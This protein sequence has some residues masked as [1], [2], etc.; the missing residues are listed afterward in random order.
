MR[1]KFVSTA[2]VAGLSLVL[3]TGGTAGAAKL[4]TGKDI[5][6]NSITS[7]DVRDRSLTPADFNGSV[8]GPAGPAGPQGA[9][10]TP[11][12]PGPKGDTGAIGP[13]GPAGPAG[14]VGPTGISGYELRIQ[15][16]DIPGRDY[17]SW[18]VRCTGA[19]KAFGGGV[20]GNF[21]TEVR[22]SAP[23]NE[24]KGWGAT[25]FNASPADY[26]AYVW[27]ICANAS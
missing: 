5:K 17:R 23:M 10:G 16:Q 9:P 19:K 7:A 15:R 18:E 21:L 26:S 11:G 14:P 13:M 2:I 4:L 25:A 22:E 12:A 1:S 24:G 6:D 3:V 8:V 20:S 27:V